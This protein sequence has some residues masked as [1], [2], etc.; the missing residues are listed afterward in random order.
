MQPLQLSYTGVET[1]PPMAHARLQL[2]QPLKLHARAQRE[3]SQW[4]FRLRKQCEGVVEQPHGRRIGNLLLKR[5]QVKRYMNVTLCSRR[6]LACVDM[7]RA[8]PKPDA[9]LQRTL[10]ALAANVEQ[11]RLRTGA[12]YAA[13]AAHVGA[14]PK[15]MNNL[16]KQRHATAVDHVV[17]AAIGLDQLG[18]PIEPWQLLVPDVHALSGDER[19]ALAALVEAFVHGNPRIREALTAQVRLMDDTLRAAL[20]DRR[21]RN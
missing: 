6:D 21:G 7:S 9:R 15:T 18:E 19:R 17:R 13:L 11:L 12:S 20:D 8:R 14:A 3:L 2:A 4:Q 16:A 10:D 1:L 5:Q